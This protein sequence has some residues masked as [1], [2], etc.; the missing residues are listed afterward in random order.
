MNNFFEDIEDAF[1]GFGWESALEVAIIAVVV[2]WMLRLLR[3]TTAMTVVRGISIVVIAIVL[4]SRVLN[5]VVLDWLVNNALAV[6]VLFVLIVFQPEFRRALER[7]GRAGGVRS[8]FGAG[9][10]TYHEIIQVISSATEHLSDQ[11]RG[12]LIVL[13]RETGLQDVV[14]TGILVD[15]V[16]TTELLEGIFFPNSPLHDGAVVVRPGRV[17]AASCILPTSSDHDARHAHLGTRH[18][19]ALGMT[20]QTDA[21]VVVVSEQTGHVAVATDGRLV[22]RLDRR[23]L[24]SLLDSLLTG[25]GRGFGHPRTPVASA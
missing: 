13:E 18:L 4:L 11:R 25:N 14:E 3:G 22:Q 8:W 16:P 2:F 23:R 1:S 20:E 19:A 21:V 12:A 24:E 7:V 6:L 15:A 5:S 9:H 10:E 17:V